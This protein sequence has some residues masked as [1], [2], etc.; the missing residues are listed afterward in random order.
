MKIEPGTAHMSVCHY[1]VEDPRIPEFMD[2][3][4]TDERGPDRPYPAH[5]ILEPS[6]KLPSLLHR[7][8]SAEGRHHHVVIGEAIDV[9]VAR[10]GHL[11]KVV[12]HGGDLS[13]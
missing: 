10:F 4:V 12:A 2:A 11:I 1:V 3:Y 9:Y 8:V 7:P 6:T 5:V 13:M